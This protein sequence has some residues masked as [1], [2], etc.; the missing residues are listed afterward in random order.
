MSRQSTLRA[1]DRDREAVAERL[2]HAA[3]EGRLEPEELE[4]RL[5]AAL[6]ARTYGDLQR[7]LADLPART[8]PAVRRALPI[9]RVALAVA[10]TLAVLAAVVIVAAVMAAWWI[11]WAILWFGFC[12]R[13]GCGGFRRAAT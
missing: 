4:E 8:E 5:H 3:V 2:R 7:L 13:R 10:L 1:A 6:R 11:V 9:M 12:A